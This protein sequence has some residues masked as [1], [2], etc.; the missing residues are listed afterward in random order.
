[1]IKLRLFARTEFVLVAT[2]VWVVVVPEFIV[3]LAELAVTVTGTVGPGLPV[4][5]APGVAVVRTGV[6]AVTAVADPPAGVAVPAKVAVALIGFALICTRKFTFTEA[7]AANE[8]RVQLTWM[9]DVVVQLPNPGWPSRT[10][11]PSVVVRL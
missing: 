3:G 7:P 10:A 2:N 1:M 5:G 11:A 6:V 4:G 8:P 9:V